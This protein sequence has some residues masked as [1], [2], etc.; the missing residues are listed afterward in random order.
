VSLAAADGLTGKEIGAR[1]FLSPKTVDFH[2]GRAY[3]KLEV[4]RGPS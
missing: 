4:S 2:L 3:R 1:L